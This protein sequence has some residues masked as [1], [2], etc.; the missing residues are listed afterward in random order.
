MA[1]DKAYD[2]ADFIAEC[3]ERQV[4][5]HV[6]MNVSEQRGSAID[7]RTTRHAGYLASQRLRKRIEECF[8]WGK[9]GRPMRKMKVVGK[10]KVAFLT[11]LT[12]GC[13]TLLRLAKLLA[14]PAPAPA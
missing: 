9:D 4:T 11:T 1:A 14:D 8:G 5:P 7:A 12:V 3:R 6:A 10:E 13:Y 2:T